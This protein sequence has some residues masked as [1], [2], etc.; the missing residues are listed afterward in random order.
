MPTMVYPGSAAALKQQLKF[1]SYWMAAVGGAKRSFALTAVAEFPFQSAMANAPS[2]MNACP[3]DDARLRRRD[4]LEQL[5][6]A[7]CAVRGADACISCSVCRCLKIP[8]SHSKASQPVY[9]LKIDYTII[10]ES[11][12]NRAFLALIARSPDSEL[13]QP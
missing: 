10:A 7:R 2:P 6:Q 12:Q 1:F 8:S 3:S 9:Q 13:P 4:L 5:D 11:L